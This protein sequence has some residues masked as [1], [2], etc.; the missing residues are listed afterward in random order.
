MKPIQQLQNLIKEIASNIIMP[1]YLKV[2]SMRKADGSVLSE[3]DLAAQV[4]FQARLPEII[5]APVLGEEMTAE[6]QHRLWQSASNSGLWVLDPIDGTNNFVNGIPHFAVSVAFIQNGQTQLGVIYSPMSDECY[7][8][9]YG[10]G[11]F[12]NHHPLPL[13]QMDK[14]LREAVAGVDIKR[15]RQAK[16]VSSINNFA[17]F[18]TLRC[19]GSSTL[20]WCYLA[21]G[22][23]DIYL[24][25]GQNLWDYAAGV[26]IAQ[27]AGVYLATLE[28]DE[29]WSGKHTFQR[30]VIA[31]GN[32]ELFTKWLH[33][34]RKNQ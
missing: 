7:F 25:G 3:A 6:V 28:N 23:F 9:E 30:S 14:R 34:V 21:A 12:L 5:D 27:E 24:H 13:H 26:L 33:W 1:Y 17:P 11:A 4:A 20:D 10:Q 31:A 19:M 8:A 15:L 2:Q 22:R 32:E 18:G 16:L 29:F